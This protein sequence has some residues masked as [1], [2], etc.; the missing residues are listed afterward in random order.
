MSWEAIA[1]LAGVIAIIIAIISAIVYV[2]EQRKQTQP[3]L[4]V[5]YIEKDAIRITNFG[6]GAAFA[7]SVIDEFYNRSF[8]INDPLEPGEYGEI[9]NLV[10][11]NVWKDIR[12]LLKSQGQI[13]E[14]QGDL[15]ISY[16]DI[17]GRGYFNKIERIIEKQD[18]LWTE[19][20]QSRPKGQPRFHISLN[21]RQ[22]DDN[23][24][25]SRDRASVAISGEDSNKG[26]DTVEV[27]LEKPESMN[28]LGLILKMIIERNLK[29]GMMADLVANTR[30]NLRLGA[31]QMKATLK[32]EGERV[33][34][35]R[36]WLIPAR[37]KVAA[38]LDT[39]LAIGLGKNPVIPFL[40]GKISLG[41]N[42][43]WLLKLMPVFQVK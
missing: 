31:G 13:R 22:P 36:D 15:K 16:K 42:L 41:G 9:T 23:I 2:K 33:V 17:Y 18:Q 29:Q 32:F 4:F 5:S 1:A 12:Q 11:F 35:A 37:A 25:S 21:Y 39:F 8:P 10:A 30:G 27:V 24:D 38:S 26:G 19:E 28:L 34:V 3:H 6:R 40:L 43:L 20:S 7:I 14:A